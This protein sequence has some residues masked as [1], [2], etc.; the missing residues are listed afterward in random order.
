[1]YFSISLLGYTL[2][3][4]SELKALRGQTS[5]TSRIEIMN[6]C[7]DLIINHF[8][9]FSSLLSEI[10]QEYTMMINSFRNIENEKLY[11]RSKVQK[12]L[13]IELEVI[14][15][16]TGLYDE[17]MRSL[18]D[19]NQRLLLRIKGYLGYIEDWL[20]RKLQS[21]PEYGNLLNRVKNEGAT[22]LSH[23]GLRDGKD[24]SMRSAENAKI[25]AELEDAKKA[26]KSK[27]REMQKLT[28][29]L[30][31]KEADLATYKS[32]IEDVQTLN[33]TLRLKL[34]IFKSDDLSGDPDDGVEF[35]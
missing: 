32:K 26:F 4:I 28:E 25:K 21:E 11:L 23:L 1:M 24:E 2:A 33:E 15:H 6:Y 17:E 9:G 13:G 31:S 16:V 5:E 3:L 29:R 35:V 20:N 7:F 30:E 12:L 8:V 14:N 22:L 10:K 27:Q 19:E 34:S 18:V